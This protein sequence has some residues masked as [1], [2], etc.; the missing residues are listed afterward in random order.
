[1]VLN[2]AV[3]HTIIVDKKDEEISYNASSPDELALINV[4]RHFGVLFEERDSDNN[5]FIYDKN[6][7]I[8][9]K[10]EVL[11]II[12]FTSTRKRMSIIVRN[13]VGKIICMSKGADSILMPR[14]KAG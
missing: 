2:L 7:N 11:N 1:M 14:L 6:L 13:D 5:V 8:R 4:A 3:C 10:Y 9:Y 12:E